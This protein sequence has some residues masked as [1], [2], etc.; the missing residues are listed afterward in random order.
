[1]ALIKRSVISL[2]PSPRT[3]RLE[4]IHPFPHRCHACAEPARQPLVDFWLQVTVLRVSWCGVGLPQLFIQAQHGRRPSCCGGSRLLV[5]SVEPSL[6][7]MHAAP[8]LSGDLLRRRVAIEIVLDHLCMC[9]VD[10]TFLI[11]GVKQAK[12]AGARVQPNRRCASAGRSRVLLRGFL[13]YN[14]WCVVLRL[15]RALIHRGL[16]E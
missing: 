6:D 8:Q 2:R 10:H 13:R 1:V 5:E 3:R 16:A 7:A 14:S 4:C 12:A 15:R 11:F 9:G